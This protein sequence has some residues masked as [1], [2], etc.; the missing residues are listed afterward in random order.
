MHFSAF[1][2]DYKMVDI[3]ATPLSSLQ[4]ARNIA[5]KN[6]IRYAY[7]GNAHDVDGDS[8]YCHNCG[9]RIIERDWY[10]LGQWRLD[11]KGCCHDCGT[12]CAGVFESGHGRWGSKRQ[13]VILANFA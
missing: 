1:H 12:Q 6:G 4:H 13:P 2:P 3:P 8:T 10:E 9:S 11:K 5:M 7:I